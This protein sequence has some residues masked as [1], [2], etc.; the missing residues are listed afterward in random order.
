M[1]GHLMRESS[2]PP[3]PIGRVAV[4]LLDPTSGRLVK[5]WTFNDQA[6]IT[7]GRSP[8]QDVEMSDPYISRNHA[9]LTYRDGQWLLISLGRHGVL[10]SN[11]LI[12]EHPIS[13]DVCF[14]LGMEGPTLRFR[15]NVE[16]SEEILA[17]VNV[18]TQ[19]MPEFQLD[20][21]KLQDDVKAIAEGHYFQ[22][23]RERAKQ[24][25]QRHRRD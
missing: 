9:N 14:R 20:A 15:T 2:R 24:L 19:Q 5:S 12:T 11:Q 10:V 16:H 3:Q 13:G 22:S 8:D 21:A 18:D 7:I 6:Q 1:V 4:H 17:T 25:R 23:L